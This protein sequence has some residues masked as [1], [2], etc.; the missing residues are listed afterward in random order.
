MQ[1]M[2]LPLTIIVWGLL[3]VAILTK[4]N[5]VYAEWIIPSQLNEAYKNAQHYSSNSNSSST[6]S[7]P[8]AIGQDHNSTTT[9]TTTTA[10]SS[11]LCTNSITLQHHIFQ[12]NC[13][14][15]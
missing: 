15:R 4:A 3:V 11:S 2:K 5:N 1:S 14:V 9:R 12:K 7:I 13:L 10:I 8:T 6:A